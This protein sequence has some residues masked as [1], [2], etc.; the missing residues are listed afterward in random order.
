MFNSKIEHVNLRV[1]QSE[2]SST[3]QRRHEWQNMGR[4]THEN[5][6]GE[7]AACSQH[8]KIVHRWSKQMQK[9]D[10]QIAYHTL[11]FFL[12]GGERSSDKLRQMCL[13]CFLS[14]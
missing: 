13:F 10:L 1:S 5:E 2:V 8:E 12:G 6:R 3:Q 9:I 4:M 11:F 14:D 7:Q